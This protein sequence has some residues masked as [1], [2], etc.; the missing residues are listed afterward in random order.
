MRPRAG[1]RRRGVAAAAPRAPLL[2]V[3]AAAAAWSAP[4]LAPVA[5]PVARALRLSRRTTAR[6]VALTFDDGPHAE[7]TPAVLDALAA[8]GAQ[9]TFFLIGEQVERHPALARRIVAD[10]HALAV[11]G[12]RHRCQLRLTAAE[13]ARDARRGAAAIEHLTG[14]RCDLYRPAYGIFS[15]GGL[16]AIRAAGFDELLWSRWGR[17][18]RSGTGPARIARLAAAEAVAGDVV[19]LHDSDAYSEP[20]CWRGTVA[21]LP[22]ILAS[23][24]AAGLAPD[25][26]VGARPATRPRPSPAPR[27]GA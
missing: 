18:W 14:V 24:A 16:R 27:G 9:A 4:A 5:A 21:A 26:L 15:A 23:I 8:G 13:V 1:D 20:G 12:Y 19:L 11:H 3:A 22:A 25:V 7:G 6:G 10:G 2:P 17:D